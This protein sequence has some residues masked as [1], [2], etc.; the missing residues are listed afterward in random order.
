MGKRGPKPKPQKL[1]NLD[2]NPEKRPSLGDPVEADGR[3]LPPDWLQKDDYAMLVWDAILTSMPPDFFAMAD[4]QILTAYCK[5][6]SVMK[7]A[8]QEI[9]DGGVTIMTKR[10]LGKNPACT[11]FAE[12]QGKVASLGTRLGLDPAARQAILGS[13]SPKKPKS[14]FE[15]LIGIDGGKK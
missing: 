7:E 3:P 2:G 12:Q 1:R 8:A 9:D 4:T 11:V 10:G 15:G 14:K 5:A 6:C 13:G